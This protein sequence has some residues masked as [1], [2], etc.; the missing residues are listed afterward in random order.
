[1]PYVNGFNI[2][3]DECDAVAGD[4]YAGFEVT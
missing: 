4:G 1:M 3:R 2:Y